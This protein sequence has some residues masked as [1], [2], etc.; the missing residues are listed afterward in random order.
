M[1]CVEP[2]IGF[3]L[4]IGQDLQ[5]GSY[6]RVNQLNPRRDRP[7]PQR[8]ACEDAGIERIVPYELRH[9]AVT[10]QLDAGHETWRVADWAGTS[11]RMV[12]IYRHRLTR[13]SALG[14]V[15][16]AVAGLLLEGPSLGPKDSVG[17]GG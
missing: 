7:P 2:T 17:D 10:F 8:T 16:V 15:A 3:D 12:E 1:K 6:V 5:I 14:P 4:I 13:V 9:T 11:E